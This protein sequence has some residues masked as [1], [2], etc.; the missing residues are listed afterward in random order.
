VKKKKAEANN[1]F[2]DVGNPVINLVNGLSAVPYNIN[3]EVINF[4]FKHGI[5]L[6]LYEHSKSEDFNSVRIGKIFKPPRGLKARFFFSSKARLDYIT[7]VLA[8]LYS[9]AK[10]F[11]FPV[12]LDFWVRVY[13]ECYALSYLGNTLAKSLLQF[14]S[15]EKIKR[16]DELSI[17]WLKAYGAAMYSKKLNKKSFND[18]VFFEG[19]KTIIKFLI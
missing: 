2:K 7:I 16:K 1:N 14:H 11:Y 4:I 18:R 5:E 17:K 3:I 15:P 10:C 19:T 8:Q 9:L 6:G 12:R 13:N